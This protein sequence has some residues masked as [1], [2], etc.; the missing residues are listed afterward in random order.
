MI[1]K[2]KKEVLLDKDDTYIKDGTYT[3]VT[4]EALKYYYDMLKKQSV[5]KENKWQK[6]LDN[7]DIAFIEKY[8]RRKKLMNIPK[9]EE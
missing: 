1:Y 6:E 5:P 7:M 4:D 8:I 3:Y 2:V 9:E